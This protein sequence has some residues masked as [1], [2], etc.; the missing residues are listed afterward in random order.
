MTIESN[1]APGPLTRMISNIRSSL[2]REEHD[3]P[4]PTKQPTNHAFDETPIKPAKPIQDDER[5]IKPVLSRKAT[6]IDIMEQPVGKRTKVVIAKQ[7][8]KQPVVDEDKD[9]DS[10]DEESDDEVED[11]DLPRGRQTSTKFSPQIKHTPTTSTSPSPSK[12]PLKPILKD[13]GIKSPKTSPKSVTAVKKRADSPTPSPLPKAHSTVAEMAAEATSLP[14]IPDEPIPAAA[15]AQT[16]QSPAPKPVRR[17]PP[18]RQSKPPEKS[19]AVVEDTLVSESTP[20]VTPSPIPAAVSP[21]MNHGTVTKVDVACGLDAPDWRWMALEALEVGALDYQDAERTGNK[22]YRPLSS[23]IEL[24]QDSYYTDLLASAIS[25][26]NSGNPGDLERSRQYGSKEALE[27][28]SKLLQRPRPWPPGYASGGLMKIIVK[29]GGVA[30]DRKPVDELAVQPQ[31]QHQPQHSNHQPRK[32]EVEQKAKFDRGNKPPP[33]SIPTRG[34]KKMSKPLSP[35]PHFT[36]LPP[37]NKGKVAKRP[38]RMSTYNNT[39]ST[40]V[41]NQ[42]ATSIPRPSMAPGSYASPTRIPVAQTSM[43]SYSQQQQ[44]HGQ[45]NVYGTYRVAAPVSDYLSSHVHHQELASHHQ[46]PTWLPR[47]AMMEHPQHDPYYGTLGSNMGYYQQTNQQQA[48]YGPTHNAAAMGP[49][50]MYTN[51]PPAALVPVEEVTKKKGKYVPAL[52]RSR[53]PLKT[54]AFRKR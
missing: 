41:Y 8:S 5:P 11:N 35:P 30:G 20:T 52:P 37:I 46:Q 19:D 31:I 45:S 51:V 23:S 27:D 22:S 28:V 15:P 33:L 18:P 29:R 9:D 39:N 10:D 50:G 1:E 43:N 54:A 4:N 38:V 40:P 2:V 3:R 32:S 47:V 6:N 7:A 25:R 53:T 17:K 44:Q 42:A 48:G 24:P 12:S 49:W 21:S 34:G 16:S 36:S 26:P 14:V 13:T